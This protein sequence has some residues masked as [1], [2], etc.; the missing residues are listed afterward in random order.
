MAKVAKKTNAKTATKTRAIV[1]KRRTA[2]GK[3]AEV[4]EL[5]KV[6]KGSVVPQSFKTKAGRDGVMNGDDLGAAVKDAFLG[7]KSARDAVD[8]LL[9]D[10]GLE[11]GRWAGKNPGMLR[12]NITNVLRGL[13]RNGK[14]VLVRG[15]KF[16]GA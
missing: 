1:R 2:K 12:M 9:N 14:D 7:G 11:V 15:K 16:K 13:R 6:K 3:K 8:A 4:V 5:P 10:N